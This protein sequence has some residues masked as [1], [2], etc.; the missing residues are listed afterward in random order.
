M[1]PF[2]FRLPA[3]GALACALCFIWGNAA[4]A[5]TNPW[6]LTN[7][8]GLAIQKIAMTPDGKAEETQ[9]VEQEIASGKKA[10][11][12]RP[13]GDVLMRV[14]FTHPD[15]TL[16][17]PV[18]SFFG[19]EKAKATLSMLKPNV[20]ELQF[21]DE[22]GL[23]MAVAGD[24]SVWGFGQILGSFPYAPG[25]T[26]LGQA[27]Q[28]GNL[29]QDAKNKQVLSGTQ[30][31]ENAKWKLTLTFAGQD[32]DSPLRVAEMR[33]PDDGGKTD[34]IIENALVAHGY[35]CFRQEPN[36]KVLNVYE[37]GGE[38]KGAMDMS[39]GVEKAYWAL[40]GEGTPSVMLDHYVP[41]ALFAELAAAHK[42]GEKAE[43][44]LAGRDDV[45]VSVLYAKESYTIT[46][47]KAADFAA[48]AK[49]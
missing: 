34:L 46:Q 23:S 28:W 24:N 32:A 48:P 33:M 1:K 35:V 27:L 43:A 31:W 5:E 21:F 20:P 11:I 38:G 14:V 17:F 25:V 2:L 15:G 41:K 19:M 12:Q 29:K 3:L 13:A 26:S 40:V 49:K 42:K 4:A 9:T 39:E 16:T 22:T 7:K 36:K 30:E 44:V 10:V 6:E 47:K 18:V 37:L 45:V 8:S